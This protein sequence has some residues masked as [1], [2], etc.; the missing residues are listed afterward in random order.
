MSCLPGLEYPTLKTHADGSFDEDACAGSRAKC[1]FPNLKTSRSPETL[2]G[3][4]YTRDAIILL[5]ITDGVVL[6]SVASAAD[7]NGCIHFLGQDFEAFCL[8]DVV[9]YCCFIQSS[10][11]RSLKLDINFGALFVIVLGVTAL[12][13]LICN[14]SSFVKW[15]P[16]L[17]HGVLLACFCC[18]AIFA[19]KELDGA[20]SGGNFVTFVELLWG[21]PCLLVLLKLALLRLCVTADCS[22]ALE[23]TSVLFEAAGGLELQTGYSFFCLF[24]HSF[25]CWR[26]GLNGCC[27][28]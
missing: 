10:L 23:L 13:S 22:V 24:F 6:S 16:I 4:P 28:I 12:Y 9:L 7:A 15:Q 25:G 26:V 19:I 17:I 3:G 21:W 5:V 11:L 14:A 18:V 20:C 27:L 1:V 2:A 8:V